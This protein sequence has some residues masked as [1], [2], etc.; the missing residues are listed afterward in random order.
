MII[1]MVGALNLHRNI[2]HVV[3]K[4]STQPIAEFQTPLKNQGLQTELNE[5]Q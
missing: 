3:V 2:Q 4:T 1:V 5:L